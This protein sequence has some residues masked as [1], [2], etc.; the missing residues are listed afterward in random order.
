MILE[1]LP[2]NYPD[3]RHTKIIERRKAV[4][5][6]E[7]VI[8]DCLS[9]VSRLL[10][11]RQIAKSEKVSHTVLRYD[12]EEQD[13]RAYKDLNEIIDSLVKTKLVFRIGDHEMQLRYVSSY[14]NSSIYSRINEIYDAEDRENLQTLSEI[15][16]LLSK[17]D[18]VTIIDQVYKN[19][20]NGI[21]KKQLE[22]MVDIKNSLNHN[23]DKLAEAEI[24]KEN[25]QLIRAGE[26][27]E[28]TT[29]TLEILRTAIIDAHQ[30]ISSFRPVVKDVMLTPSMSEFSDQTT[31]QE[32]L[33]HMEGREE[34]YLA[35]RSS[36]YAY[37]I[38]IDRLE[39]ERARIAGANLSDSV[40]KII[41][42]VHPI[43]LSK[44]TPISDTRIKEIIDRK[45]VGTVITNAR[46]AGIVRAEDVLNFLEF[47]GTQ[48]GPME[49][50]AQAIPSSPKLIE[51]NESTISDMIAGFSTLWTQLDPKETE[52]EKYV[53]PCVIT[54]ALTRNMDY[55]EILEQIQHYKSEL[56]KYDVEVLKSR[57]NELK[58][59]LNA[60]N[61]DY[62][63]V[64]NLAMD[65]AHVANHPK[66]QQTRAEGTLVIE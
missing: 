55:N 26:N 17:K 54:N 48:F 1:Q 15:F 30:Q 56:A 23:L 43:W 3:I 49:G 8:A 4:E 14:L 35:L 10:V 51:T 31:I 13:S 32:A 66:R 2:D 37:P 24:I 64:S 44:D 41:P 60:K 52:P 65:L 47:Y 36:T 12:I 53:I 6:S 33:D 19:R 21:N 62:S 57:G 38:A 46:C 40:E 28:K 27:I 22:K 50:L 58:K 39:I 5:I 45:T 63:T 20:N 59:L 18:R 7:H 34:R 61:I 29:V 25:D 42:L 9:S 11:H 16:E